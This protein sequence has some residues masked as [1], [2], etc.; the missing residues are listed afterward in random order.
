[1]GGTWGTVL[2]P[3][4]GDDDIDFSALEDEL[5]VLMA[6]GLAGLYTCGTAGEF[7][8]L[9]EDEFDRLNQL[10]AQRCSDHGVRFQV[11]ASH[12]SG[13]VC[14]SRIARARALQPCAVQVILPDWLPLSWSETLR[15]LER[16]AEAA[17]PVPLVLYNPPHSKT[18]LGPRQLAEAASAVPALAGVKVAG[19]EGFYRAL[20]D[21]APALAVFVPGHELS[22]TRPLGVAGS[23]SNVACLQPAGAAAWERQMETDPASAAELGERVVA[24]F[25]RQ[26]APLRAQGYCNT[27]LDKA[28]AAIGEWA[29]VGTRVRWPYAAV[30]DHVVEDLKPK[31]RSA[32]PELFELATT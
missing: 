5:Y 27:A 10:V 13:Q 3:I 32:V 24:F 20:R 25:D 4:I 31:A 12:M 21:A 28:L 16:M 6:A 8:T 30:P 14:L 2:L 7:Y 11:G 1:L 19:S 22:R 15:T 26:M 29:P 9:D 23:Y 17:D 18:V